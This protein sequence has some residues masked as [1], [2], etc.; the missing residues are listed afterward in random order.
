MKTL[1][2]TLLLAAVVQGPPAEQ[3]KPATVSGIVTRVGSDAPI[4][5]AAV[6]INKPGA[7]AEG[8]YTVSTGP[9]GKFT[10]KNIPPGEYT[11]AATHSGFVRGEYL[12]RGPNS[13]GLPFT[14]A[15]AQEL[16]DAKI[17]LTQTAA[18]AGRVLDRKGRPSPYVQVQALRL[19]F[20][21]NQRVLNPARVTTTNDLGEYRLFW[22]PPGQYAVMALPLRGSVPDTI[23]NTSG[24]YSV[25]DAIL[26]PVGI[27][28]ILSPDEA[29]LPIFY[30]GTINAE[31]ATTVTLR[32]GEDMRGI[33][34][35]IATTATRKIRGVVLNRPA[36]QPA[37]GVPQP[38]L[39]N[40]IRLVSRNAT[41]TIALANA[42]LASG[43]AVPNAQ[44]GAFE[45]TGVLPGSYFLVAEVAAGN[46][47]SATTMFGSVPIEVGEM[48]IENVSIP[49]AAGFEVPIH[50]TLEGGDVNSAT[51]DLARVQLG[52]TSTDPTRQ[53]LGQPDPQRP[54]LR[55]ARSIFPGTYS[56]L[57]SQNGAPVGYVKS[58][59]VNGSE[60]ARRSFRLDATPSAPIEVVLS[61]KFGT[62]NGTAV[63]ATQ[64]PLAGVTV[65][66]V[67]VG[68]GGSFGYK[69]TDAQGRYS[70][71][72]LW[73]GDYRILAF[74]DIELFSW[75][76]ADH[77]RPYEN[78]GRSIHVD[79]GA[80]ESLQVTVI[81]AGR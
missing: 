76:N 53:I 7:P 43:T 45:I 17:G 40:T 32:S 75:Q 16:R 77:M 49:L 15:P 63:S 1:L 74:E 50:V 41:P 3:P 8:G 69:V 2:Q 81:P 51:A 64:Q 26:P 19:G 61:T 78:Q 23:I 38:A 9:D 42:P 58:I 25:M 22:L 6:Q 18:I 37:G 68:T 56:V 66:A 65:V 80:T 10:I 36:P 12:Q 67:P 60:V 44:T 24:S 62:I 54:D 70:L 39:R 34:L 35:T 46:N 79:E 20:R 55:I 57:W 14:L 11:L 71:T 28:T 48:D 4:P 52:L 13:K 27:P 73:P 72:G 33:D 29:T 59:T 5:G 47:S 31:S 21:G 30:P